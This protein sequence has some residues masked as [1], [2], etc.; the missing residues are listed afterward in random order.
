MNE[1]EVQYDTEIILDMA[2]YVDFVEYTA[3]PRK[4]GVLGYIILGVLTL[5]CLVFALS[6]L[7]LYISK[8]NIEEKYEKEV[9]VQEEDLVVGTQ[10]GSKEEI[11]ITETVNLY[12]NR[13]H[14]GSEWVYLDDYCIDG[15]Q[16]YKIESSYRK[17]SKASYDSDDCMS[18]GIK[19]FATFT[20][21]NRITNI[22]ED[23]DTYYVYC[24]VTC[25]DVSRLEE[26]YSSCQQDLS[27]WVTGTTLSYGEITKFII[28][29]MKS[30]S[31]PTIETD[32]VLQVKKVDDEYLI[33]SDSEMLSL[34]QDAYI[35]SMS[36]LI[37]VLGRTQSTNY[38]K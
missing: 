4:H 13:L 14:A 30:Y 17:R 20:N 38:F 8:S 22:T 33:V 36:T 26:F 19:Q 25:I 12:F 6:T 32:Y 9:K 5:I 28:N 34:V 27:Y 23:N 3:Q 21:L 31:P 11:A 15:S 10:V 7:S 16:C 37:D 24:N 35:T 29:N 2:E 1:Q 18:R